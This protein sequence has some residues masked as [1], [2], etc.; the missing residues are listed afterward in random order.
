[1]TLASLPGRGGLNAE[2]AIQ[3]SSAGIK[4]NVNTWNR[5]APTSIVGL[6]WSMEYSRIVCDHKGST[7]R[8]DDVFY[9]MEGGIL[10]RM[11][12][13]DADLGST[14]RKYRTYELENR[15]PWIILYYYLDE[16]WV[17]T[18]DNGFK[19][20]FG[21]NKR[22][23]AD[24]T[25]QY[26]VGWGNWI[27]D[28]NIQAGQVTLAYVW[29]MSSVENVWGDKLTY[30]YDN[31][32]ENIGG[33]TSAKKHTRAS[34][35]KKIVGPT[36]NAVVMTYAEKICERCEAPYVVR[37]AIP[38]RE[39]QDPHIEVA[40]PDAY[41]E[42]YESRYLQKVETYDERNAL[43]YT[44][45]L[46]YGF[47]KG[48]NGEF[49]KRILTGI[50]RTNANGTKIPATLFA[51]HEKGDEK[52]YLSSIN[53]SA[54][55]IISYTYRRTNANSGIGKRDLSIKAPDLGSPNL[56]SS[57]DFQIGPDYVI[58]VWRKHEP[59]N[60]YAGTG[61]LYIYQWKGEWVE[62]NMGS[63][64]QY[65]V[66]LKLDRFKVLYTLQPDFFAILKRTENNG[67]VG[68]CLNKDLLIFRKTTHAKGWEKT[69][70]K[71][72]ELKYWHE[73][74][75]HQCDEGYW[76]PETFLT[77]GSR[78][79]AVGSRA[80]PGFTTYTWNGTA[81]IPKTHETSLPRFDNALTGSD[82][83][84]V[85]HNNDVKVDGLDLIHVWYLT[86]D[87]QWTMKDVAKQF[88][89]NSGKAKKDPDGTD[90][91]FW[92]N[93]STFSLCMADDNPEF[94]YQW[95][96]NYNVTA[97][98][99]LFNSDRD[100][101]S[102]IVNNNDQVVFNDYQFFSFNGRSWI[103][104]DM[105]EWYPTKD[106]IS[107]PISDGAV[108]LYATRVFY[109]KQNAIPFLAD[110]VKYRDAFTARHIGFDRNTNAWRL[111]KSVRSPDFLSAGFF[112]YAIL[113]YDFYSREPD[114]SWLNRGNLASNEGEVISVDAAGPNAFVESFSKKI[115]QPQGPW[116]NLIPTGT[117][118]HFMKNGANHPI[119]IP[120]LTDKKVRHWE[121]SWKRKRFAENKMVVAF[122]PANIFK[123]VTRNIYLFYLSDDDLM[124]GH[125]TMVVNAILINDGYLDLKKS[126]SYNEVTATMGENG[127]Y[128]MFNEVN[129]INGSTDPARRPKGVTKIFYFNRSNLSHEIFNNKS[130]E[131]D[132][133]LGARLI[134]SPYRTEILNSGNEKLVETT[135]VFNQFTNDVVSKNGS[136]TRIVGKNFFVRPVKATS[137]AFYPGNRTSTE[138][139][140]TDYS[141]STGLVL[142]LKKFNAAK[143]TDATSSSE[144]FYTYYVDKYAEPIG[145]S[146]SALKN[147]ISEIV[148]VTQ[149][150]NGKIISS[151]ATVWKQSPIPQP[152]KK[153]VWR[154][155]GSADFIHY[156]GTDPG[157]SW[158][159]TTTV[160]LRDG[161]GNILESTDVGRVSEVA[162]Y[163]ALKRNPIV[164]ARYATADRVAYTSFEEGQ[165]QGWTF[166]TTAVD[167]TDGSAFTGIRSLKNQ[168]AQVS[169][170]V[171]VYELYYWYKGGPVSH[172]I[173]GGKVL[174]EFDVL[175]RLGWRQK[176]V[177]IDLTSTGIVQ[178]NVNGNLDELRI[179]PEGAYVTSFVF[180][181]KEQKV[182][183]TNANMVTTYFYYDDYDR[184]HLIADDN[185]NILKHY[186]Y[187]FKKAEGK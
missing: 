49:D 98:P 21:D 151:S 4:Q 107:Q 104:Y 162:F 18:K 166:P 111:V 80:S 106:F 96:Q 177:L 187:G 10:N 142:K 30:Y 61:Y 137:K 148:G 141:S 90:R 64:G 27:G 129:V 5:E 164:T 66:S 73:R 55:G 93:T 183:E 17:I 77:S 160:S 150:E 167:A 101:R 29:N 163:D 33:S 1:M 128:P 79:L 139:N 7:S 131:Q 60:L 71:N 26:M 35:L 179:H 37:G 117:A 144:A 47:L 68:A 105:G 113:G 130:P 85:Y 50:Q 172:N 186:L 65:D 62:Y 89:F 135:T 126:F 112:N 39:Y 42:K 20:V 94:L 78:Y 36:G 44:V 86:E 48:A 52:G 8:H 165:N 43:L 124:D 88:R 54:G 95:D 12:C 58:V 171:G 22:G 147:I 121:E 14:K 143:E 180:N 120:Y 84:I 181:D 175:E 178:V 28:S 173:T 92:Y 45:D 82:N 56:V 169:L 72:M 170:P 161:V 3:Y 153:Y 75:A 97:R 155:Y 40:E 31:I 123:D 59:Y 140:V 122:D 119:I 2:V 184:P 38:L 133:S 23:S 127:M 32:E 51:Y 145:T 6:G 176:K 53:N 83:Y 99:S 16:K 19:V 157:A 100:S 152:V 146:P 168:R 118:V 136:K 134:G 108:G 132:V 69:V 125:E 158:K 13:T 24:G 156:G 11:I 185:K 41:Q 74:D 102:I 110:R 76:L 34:A 138:T 46:S 67:T 57:A 87:L 103:S 154:G 116:Q 9:L 70:V 109:K 149:K 15:Q 115:L 182:A 114:G 174:Q 91:S 25:I 63:I 81:W 159:L